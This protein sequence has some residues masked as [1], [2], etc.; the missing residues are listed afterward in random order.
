[1]TFRPLIVRLALA[2]TVCLSFFTLSLSAESP[3]R[4]EVNPGDRVVMIG[5]TLAE[6]MLY[7]GYF[8][9][10]LYSRFPRHDLVVRNLGWSADELSIR[11]R[12]ASFKDHGH[13]LTDH[14][15]DVL[16]AF[17]GFNESFA[18][19]RGLAKFEKDLEKSIAEWTTT[20]YNGKAPP[21]LALVSPI[22]NEDLSERNLS[23]GKQNNARI[24]LYVDAMK[25][26]A[27]KHDVVFVDL[28]APTEKLMGDSA[29]KRLTFNGIHLTESG[30]EQ[31]ASI[32]DESLFGA[33]PTATKTDPKLL[34]AEV[35][36]KNR[37]FWFDYRACNAFYIYGGRKNPF[38]VV[39]FPPEFA[40]LRK[41]IAKRE[42]RI[43]AIAQG[44]EVTYKIDDSDT[45][46]LPK[47]ET[48]F[49]GKISILAPQEELETFKLPPGYEI[50]LFASEVDFPELQQPVQFTF[51]AKGRLWV[52]VMPS[53]PHY[54]PGKPVNDKILILEDTNNDGRADKQT[55]FA[56][57]L[58]LPT[59]I[60][61]G[62]RGCYVAKQRNLLFLRD[63]DGDDRADT[64]EI[65]LHGF[66]S[67]DSHHAISA[68]TWGPGGALHFQEGTFNQSQ[69]ETPYGPQ[70][71]SDAGVYRYD[72]RRERLDVF[73]SYPFAN[74]WGHVFDRW[75][76][77]FVAD[78]SGGANY[79]ATA[80][81][82]AVDYP[83][84]HDGMKQFLEKQ[85][86]PTCG[87]EFVSSSNFPDE[88]QGDYLL[89]NDIGFQGTLQYRMREEGSGFAAT[90]VDPL[91]RS[92]DPSYRPVDIKFG[93]DGALYLCDWYNPLVGHMQHSVRDPNRDHT[94]GRIW[95]VRYKDR[96]LVVPPKIA[97]EPIPELLDLLK[98]YEDRTRYTVR[99]ELRDRDTKEVLTAVDKWIAGLDQKDEGYSHNL[100]EALWVQQQHDA[101]DREL[102]RKLL[103]SDD[104]RV[105]AAATRVLCYSQ[106]RVDEP[107]ALLQTQINDDHPR[108]RL[109]AIRALSFFD[110]PAAEKALEIAV[111][112][113]VHE[114]D[115]YLDYT[116]K[117]TMAT[118]EGRVKRNAK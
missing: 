89:N 24:K 35:L 49:P 17:F 102:L 11:L 31:V 112:G 118:L 68:F 20:K 65:A 57:G 41:M 15:P 84:K 44:Q 36:E 70:R 100:L 50:N 26:L 62:D 28:F 18:G 88:V 9:T 108:V 82:G 7:H 19:E 115:D 14:K 1:M 86:R 107:L 74:P 10:L 97:G 51:D 59:G 92:S 8:E 34:R 93:P 23:A 109:E 43:W 37:Q 73:V 39:N 32:L 113:L 46:D 95:R 110:G 99:R 90:P 81:S 77:N 98:T 117:E 52:A 48:N 30:D 76:Q 12:T 91:V 83:R 104:Y 66:D 94:H 60:E 111:E 61:L 33:Q 116:T 21:R 2:F 25:R 96:P 101:V 38:G 63:T 72:P 13:E 87:C 42:E 6:R 22:A 75:G 67:S 16:L 69:I 105:R 45:G 53:Y 114:Q 78:A 47:I 71:C 80:F 64:E 3:Q 106:H 40:K 58:Y 55:I 5:N 85:W 56:E 54:L 103:R 27:A 4:L 79:F 29:G